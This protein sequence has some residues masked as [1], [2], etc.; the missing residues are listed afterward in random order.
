MGKQTVCAHAPD[1][2]TKTDV[3]SEREKLSA[4]KKL[5]ATENLY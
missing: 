4:H 2:D 1:K 3:W 5:D